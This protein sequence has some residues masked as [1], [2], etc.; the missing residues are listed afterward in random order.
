MQIWQELFILLIILIK[1]NNRDLFAS[2]SNNGSLKLW[3]INTMECIA[4]IELLS[5]F[6]DIL[7]NS[8]F[9]MN[10]NNQLYI[11]APF[12]FDENFE[13]I[14][15]YD[16]KGIKVKEINIKNK[17]KIL[18]FLIVIVIMKKRQKKLYFFLWTWISQIF[19]C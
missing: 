6:G 15:L 7:L 4:V 8:L 19:W 1:K 5:S 14:D 10:L 16:L 3:N 12:T 13:K 18:E 9:F 11:A 2:Y 17:K